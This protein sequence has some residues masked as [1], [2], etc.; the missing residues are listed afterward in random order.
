MHESLIEAQTIARAK[1]S[2]GDGHAWN[3]RPPPS[4]KLA[5]GRGRGRGRGRMEPGD[6]RRRLHVDVALA[7]VPQPVLVARP[8]LPGRPPRLLVPRLVG[9]VVPA[10]SRAEARQAGSHSGDLDHPAG[11]SFLLALARAKLLG[12]STAH[13]SC[14]ALAAAVSSLGNCCC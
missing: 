12:A 2:H 9:V 1:G 13:D 7:N 3:H 4:T 14:Q 10:S 8:H 11:R 6:E 5:R